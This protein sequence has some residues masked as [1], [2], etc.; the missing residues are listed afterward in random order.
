V[1]SLFTPDGHRVTTR[2]R[3]RLSSSL[4]KEIVTTCDESGKFVFSG[5]SNATYT[6]SVDEDKDFETVSEQVDIALS[7]RDLPQSFTVMLRLVPKVKTVPSPKVIR[8]ENAEVPKKAMGFYNAAV[9]LAEKG[10][11]AGA[12]EQLKQAVSAYPSFM[13]AYTELG[14]QYLSMNDL[15]NAETSL[16]AAL[17]LKRDAYEPN[18]NMGI[19]LVR[20]KRFAEAEA[21]LRAALKANGQS[22]VAQFYL[23]RSFIAL[24][25]LP[26]AEA[27][28]KAS[29]TLSNDSLK[30]AH[31]VLA[32]LY[33]DTGD[34]PKAAAEIETYLQANPAAADAENL[35]SV[36]K[37][38]KDQPAGQPQKP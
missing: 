6:V 22:A 9:E 15:A 38:I 2:I 1:G 13:L 30:E 26:E 10:D 3:I 24:K 33:L 8:T 14:V 18:V 29:I 28:L 23:G 19:L 4:G 16:A 27:A 34:Y 37:Q 32:S 7:N 11:R 25:R 12:V 21:P 31:R 20:G 36:L 5:L 35:R 17:K